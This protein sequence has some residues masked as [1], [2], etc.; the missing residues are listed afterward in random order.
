MQI[1]RLRIHIICSSFIWGSCP[2]LL[3]KWHSFI[4]NCWLVGPCNCCISYWVLSVTLYTI[5]RS[6]IVAT[7]QKFKQLKLKLQLHDHPYVTIII[8]RYRIARVWKQL[9]FTHFEDWMWAELEILVGQTFW[10]FNFWKI[11]GFLKVLKIT[12]IKSFMQ[13][14]S[15]MVCN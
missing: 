10:N 4:S 1:T 11:I 6:F 9:N 12:S 3:M 7:V 13:I 2:I 8:A 14:T 5:I 15:Y